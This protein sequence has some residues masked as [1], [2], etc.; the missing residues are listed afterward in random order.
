MDSFLGKLEKER[1]IRE[2]QSAEQKQAVTQLITTLKDHDIIMTQA[3]KDEVS[4]GLE[5]LE[6][7]M[8]VGIE[9]SN[10]LHEIHV[11]KIIPP[12]T[13]NKGKSIGCSKKSYSDVCSGPKTNDHS[14]SNEK[15]C[16][17]SS[18]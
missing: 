1:L 7:C 9:K 17:S 8:Q 4:K 10:A 13:Q 16:S 2:K 3:Y 5:K 12:T 6:Q 11:K 18:R 14:S 15:D